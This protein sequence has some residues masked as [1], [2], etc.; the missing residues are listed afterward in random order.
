MNKILFFYFITLLPFYSIGSTNDISVKMKDLKTG[1]LIGDITIKSSLYGVVFTPN[2][3][4][5]EPGLHG[6]HIHEKGDCGT[7]LMNGI[8]IL[9]GKAGGHY[10]PEKAK[11]HGFPWT[12]DNHKGDLPPLYVDNNGDATNPVLA[13]RIKIKELKGKSIMV[14]KGS[15]N[16]SDHPAPLGGGYDRISCGVIIN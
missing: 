16:H 4:N 6:F 14:H 10:D 11:K 12:T 1:E 8:Y 13:P 3:I 15:D 2:L 9:G 5:L 7:A